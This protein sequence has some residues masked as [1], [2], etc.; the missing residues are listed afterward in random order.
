M[1]INFED[2]VKWPDFVT[3]RIEEKYNFFFKPVKDIEKEKEAVFKWMERQSKKKFK[4]GE[5]QHMREVGFPQEKRDMLKES[6]Q[7]DVELFFEK[8]RAPLQIY[9]EVTR[10]IIRHS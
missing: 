5:E 7:K 9:E 2:I 4:R 10:E 1:I 6:I 3:K 8:N